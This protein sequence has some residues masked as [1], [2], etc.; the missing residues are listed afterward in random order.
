MD[1]T[2]P[3]SSWLACVSDALATHPS[4]ILGQ[5]FFNTSVGVG[6]H[7][8][9]VALDASIP[10]WQAFLSKKDEMANSTNW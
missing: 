8:V 7:L 1:N 3:L 4:R 2:Y 5:A 9:L 10:S 6:F